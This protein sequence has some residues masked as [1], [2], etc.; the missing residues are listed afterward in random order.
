MLR[1]LLEERFHL[2]AHRET[3]VLPVYALLVGK[4]GPRHLEKSTDDGPETTQPSGIRRDG[5][6][7]WALRN[8]TMAD[9]AFFVGKLAHLDVPAV[10]STGID[11]KFNFTFDLLARD[12]ETSPLEYQSVVFP[13]LSAQLGLT[14]DR[15][16]AP[17]EVLVIDNVDKVPTEN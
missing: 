17:T 1:K 4:E 12:P 16:K 6:Q 8:A 9:F 14:I 5:T 2:A 13:A 3:R 10:D 15:R 11:G 7:H